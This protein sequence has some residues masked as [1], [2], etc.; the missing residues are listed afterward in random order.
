MEKP[1]FLIHVNIDIKLIMKSPDP[2]KLT[3]STQL[4]EI[5]WAMFMPLTY[6]EKS[7]RTYI[8]RVEWLEAGKILLQMI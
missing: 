3:V 1:V 8:W 5:V 6:T 4:G 2:Y 7:K